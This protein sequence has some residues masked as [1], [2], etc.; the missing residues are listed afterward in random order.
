MCI[1]NISPVFKYANIPIPIYPHDPGEQRDLASPGVCTWK[2]W[3][4]KAPSDPASYQ[5]LLQ[6]IRVLCQARGDFVVPSGD[7]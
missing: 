7:D 4:P 2:G 3:Q 1:Y 6:R 5:K